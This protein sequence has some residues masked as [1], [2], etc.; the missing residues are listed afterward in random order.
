[1]IVKQFI[2][3]FVVVRLGA[4]AFPANLNQVSVEEPPGELQLL[5][6]IARHG[7][8]TPYWIYKVCHNFFK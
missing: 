1:M 3:F 8:R 4:T 6:I 2:L 7:D 5:Q